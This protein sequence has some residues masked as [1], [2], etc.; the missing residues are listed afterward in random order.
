M[1]MLKYVIVSILSVLFI[2]FS[3]PSVYVV[4]PGTRAIVV[5]MGS[6]SRHP[7]GE[8][9]HV[10]LSFFA[11]P[12]LVP[13]KQTP[14]D[15]EGVECF[16]S[17]LQ[18]IRAHLVVLYH[19]PEES[20]Y[21]VAVQYGG[22][23]ATSFVAPRVGEALKETT[24]LLTAEEIVKGREQVK[25]KA[26]AAAR[27]KLGDFIVLDDLV[28]KEV[29]LSDELEHA[30]EQ[31][32]VQEQEAQKQVFIQQKTKVEAETAAIRAEGAAKARL[33]AA[34]ADAKL[35]DMRGAA[36]RR[37]PGTI[38]LMTVEKWNGVTPLVIGKDASPL[39][40]LPGN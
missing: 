8:G 28:I 17:D 19:I 18:L 13:I 39:L 29:N 37:N 40:T 35:I 22:D 31:K 10:K 25:H 6:A 21:K 7:V 30:I 26:L 12:I 33:I 23:V 3:I 36:L 4:D 27:A 2:V 1:N 5:T 14:A 32:M 20:V 15:M 11:K 38:D 24:A 9:L 34:E 16:S